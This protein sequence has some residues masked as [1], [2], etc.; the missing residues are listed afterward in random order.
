MK[1]NNGLAEDRLSE[2]YS[3]VDSRRQSK[4]LSLPS[5]PQAQQLDSD[6]SETDNGFRISRH[7][8]GADNRYWDI[9]KYHTIQK[10][11]KK[12][13]QIQLMP[14]EKYSDIEEFND[15][16]YERSKLRN[17]RKTSYSKNGNS[18]TSMPKERPRPFQV[19]D[20][21]RYYNHVFSL[22]PQRSL[23]KNI[24]SNDCFQPNSLERAEI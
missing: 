23:A 24:Y 4:S 11:S 7:L 14:N 15:R 22:K 6:N 19:H 10:L 5:R 13:N 17:S 16:Q 9:N 8:D 20:N 1:T 2:I 21:E 18:S 3:G 12:D